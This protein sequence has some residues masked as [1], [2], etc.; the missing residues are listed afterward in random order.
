MPPASFLQGL[1]CNFALPRPG[2]EPRNLRRA[3]HVTVPMDH[4]SKSWIPGLRVH[5]ICT[6][7]VLPLTTPLLR[8]KV[9]VPVHNP[10]IQ[11]TATLYNAFAYVS[12]SKR[13]YLFS[14]Q[15]E[16]I[17]LVTRMQACVYQYPYG[18]LTVRMCGPAQH[19][20]H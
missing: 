18:R 20:M 5:D 2:L 17:P 4:T 15:G 12:Q 13:E 7:Q 14:L 3:Y 9:R 19:S 6:V 11:E 1:C 8:E 16:S 10:P